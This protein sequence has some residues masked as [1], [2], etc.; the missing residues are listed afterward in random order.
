MVNSELIETL[1]NTVPILGITLV[2]CLIIGK[3][4]KKFGVPKVSGYIILGVIL[5][6][7]CLQFL[8]ENFSHSFKYFNDLALGMILFNIGGE[9]NR[10]LISKMRKEQILYS[11]VSVGFTILVVFSL[12]LISLYSIG[13]YDNTTV[14]IVSIFLALVSVE[15]APPTTLLVLKEYN[16][17]GKLSDSIKIYLAFAT[18]IAIVT[19]LI[20]TNAFEYFGLWQGKYAH[21]PILIVKT[22]WKVF[23]SMIFGFILG[24]ILTFIERYETRVGNILF[25]II[26]VILFGQSLAEYLSVDPLIISLFLGFTVANASVEGENIH[27]TVKN[28]GGS[29]YALFFVLAGTHIKISGLVESVGI[30][31]VVYIVSRMTGII[32]GSFL[33][34]KFVGLKD[35]NIKNYQ[36]MSVM[37]HAGAALA[38]VAKVSIYKEDSAQ[39]I[40]NTVVASIFIFEVLGPF[41]LKFALFKSGQINKWNPEPEKTTKLKFNLLDILKL[42]Q[43]NVTAAK[44]SD[45]KKTKS[46]INELIHTDIIAIKSDANLTSI[47][48]F[49]DDN[50]ALY[51]V[52]DKSHCFLGTL[53]LDSIRKIV[54][55]DDND[56]LITANTLIGESIFIPSNSTLEGAKNI[57]LMSGK[58]ILPVVNPINQVLEGILYQKDT[59]IALQEKKKILEE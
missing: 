32:S 50:Y 54:S 18:L 43:E 17:E 3:L 23:G 55:Q 30:I 58:D 16:A 57:F 12:F 49:I 46:E 42:F 33:A 13:G 24:V 21:S 34:A 8:S 29:I 44:E 26:A 6:P 4:S 5:G 15:A 2:L 48:T 25:S 22:I 37:S 47:K 41:L 40:F 59:L 53:N 56:P 52:V 10:A 38:I 11:V 7:G 31:G 9:F 27:E 19:T 28:M 51:P 45:N 1:N 39:L 36:G 14:I 35:D 20:A